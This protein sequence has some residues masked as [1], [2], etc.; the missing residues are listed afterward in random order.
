MTLLR[1]PWFPFVLAVGFPLTVYSNNQAA[2]AGDDVVRP[3]LIFL[4]VAV[5]LI[6]I[7]RRAV[8]N[9][10]LAYFLAALPLTSIWLFGFGWLGILTL[11]L[12]AI[13]TIALRARSLPENT[14]PVFNALSIGVLVVPLLSIMRVEL[15]TAGDSLQEIA[16]S[17]FSAI[18]GASI[19]NS[20]PDIYHIVLDAYAG[21]DALAAELGFDNSAFYNELRQLGFTV[22]DSIVAPYNETV[23][24]M[25]AI[26]LGE[27]LQEDEFPVSATY[28]GRLR[29]TLGALIPNGPVQ[30]VLRANG[31]SLIFTDPGHD[32]LRFPKD[33]NVLSFA[34]NR[35]LNRFEMHLGLL[36]GLDRFVPSLYDVAAGDPLLLSLDNSLS[37]DYAE[38]DSP[39]FIYEHILAPHTP[40]TIDRH[41]RQTSEFPGFATTSEGDSVVFDDPELREIYVRGYLEKIRFVNSRV[42]V[43]LRKLRE[44]PGEKIIVVHGDH[45]SGSRYF[46]NDPAKTCLRERF[47]TFLAVYADEPRTRDR[48]GWVTEADASPVNIYRSIMN[49][50]LDAN[51]DLL[52]ARSA[53]VRWMSPHEFVPLELA[54]IREACEEPPGAITG[55]S[56]F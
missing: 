41:G 40:F 43:Q 32:F 5:L 26:F 7:M 27:Y 15:T 46:L 42:L 6:M 9:R 17:P 19:A 45:G 36:A 55:A 47:T 12:W 22:N 54:A 3:I 23:H 50:L 14:T 20:K 24:T 2:F 28:P 53:F 21:S 10:N 56:S 11:V 30:E 4:L 16:Y 52:P 33:A 48:F 49:G 1:I 39:K 25:S 37:R 51:L 44:L 35:P 31:Y 29:S 18:R 8:P 34:G 38:F 13:A